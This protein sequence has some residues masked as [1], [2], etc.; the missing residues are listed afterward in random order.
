MSLFKRK[1]SPNWWVKLTPRSAKYG[2]IVTAVTIAASAP[3]LY[4]RYYA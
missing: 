2:I 1:D 3:Y 4:F